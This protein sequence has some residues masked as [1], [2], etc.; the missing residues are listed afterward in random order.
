[1][2]TTRQKGFQLTD[3]VACI[4]LAGGQGTRLFPL[5]KDRCKP[6]VGFGGRYRLIDIPISNS[7]N[8]N[9]NHLFI[10]SQYFSSGLNQHVSATY[11]LDKFQGGGLSLLSPEEK[12]DGK[13]WYKG[14]A[15]AVRQNIDNLTKLPVDYFL[16]LSGDQLYNMDL[17]AMVAFAY[18]KEADLTLAALP[19][20]SREAPRLGILNI[21]EDAYISDFHEKPKDPEI[22]KRFE[23]SD[24]FLQDNDIHCA[25]PPCFLASMGIYLFKKE[26][27]IS[28]LKEDERE[29]FGKHLIPT[30]LSR[31]RGA[32]FLHQ[33]YWE[34][35]GT[36]S[37]FY[38]A[39][40][41][42]TTN[43]LGL[44]L[45]NEVLPI[46]AHNHFLPGAR[47]SET[48]VKDSIICDGAI[49]EAKEIT[50]SVIGVRSVV[51]RGSVIRDSILLGNESYS[52]PEDQSHRFT[53]GRECQI[54]TTIID[55]NVTIG[56]NVRLTNEKK[57][58]N[59]DGEGIYI[60]DGIIVV[61]S[62]TT[63]PDNF[64]L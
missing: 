34:D 19:V 4:I 58:Q 37:S 35:I 60:R 1:M 48:K 32:V 18:E 43:T 8:S 51:K 55:E 62:G 23:M 45:Y 33:G 10:I 13:V 17:E 22:L 30:Q 41:S 12:P 27:L 56:N 20:S 63:L 39:N 14:T 47:L 40:L 24:Q 54:E 31:G 28:L 57:L 50:H 44:N 15:D 64:S 46:Y 42:L 26:V 52:T 53:I 7:L 2:A 16:I 49:V 25:G 9:M 29:D 36:I 61:S 5:T 6:A 38:Q 59:Y 3:R 21:D 11:H